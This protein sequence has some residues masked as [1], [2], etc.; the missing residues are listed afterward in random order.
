MVIFVIEKAYV[1][2]LTMAFEIKLIFRVFF[3]WAQTRKQAVYTSL[4]LLMVGL[5]IFRRL[6]KQGLII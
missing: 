4:H 5:I 3:N 6:C 1:Q 2:Y